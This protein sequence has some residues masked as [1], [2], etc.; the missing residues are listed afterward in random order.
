MIILGINPGAKYL[1][2]A[3]FNG[4]DLRDWGLKVFKG[5]WSAAKTKKILEV[6]SEL[7][8]RHEPTVLAIKDLDPAR[9]SPQLRRA[10][11]QIKT[12]AEKQGLL[13]HEYSI[14]DME[15]FFSPEKRINKKQLAD[16]LSAEYSVLFSDLNR[17]KGMRNPYHLRMFEAV[18]LG[19]SC[20]QRSDGQKIDNL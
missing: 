14:R 19:S 17:E 8:A 13:I 16:I 3:V 2:F 4:M 12:L 20:A 7:L 6:V 9:S 11:L 18:A 5:T 10:V 15:R 1:G